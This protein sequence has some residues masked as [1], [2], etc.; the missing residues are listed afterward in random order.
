MGNLLKAYSDLELDL[1]MSNIELVQLFSYTRMYFDMYSI[2][3]KKAPMWRRT[4]GVSDLT[5]NTTSYQSN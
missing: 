4:S 1:T 3:A 5:W 2:V